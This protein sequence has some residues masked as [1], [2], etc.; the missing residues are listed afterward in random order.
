MV[1]RFARIA[2]FAALLPLGAVPLAASAQPRPAPAPV[3]PGPPALSYADLADLA[4]PAP[5]VTHV[6]LRRALALRPEDSAG[7]AP[8]HT[9]FYME[10]EQV[11]LIR[12]PA[13]A[14]AQIKYLVDLPNQAN[15]R[16]QRPARRSEYLIFAR[17]VPGRAEELQLVAPDAQLPF[18][19]GTADRIRAILREAVAPDAAEAITGIGRA[20]HVPGVLQG[21]SE[22]QVF[23]L[24]ARNQPI[25]ITIR[26]EPQVAPRWF[27]S[28]SEFVDAGATQPA[29]DTLLWYRLACFLP[30]E[31]PRASLSETPEHAR[32]IAA[33][34]ALVRQELG[35]CTRIRPRR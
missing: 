16:A 1:G 18:A 6:R 28:L 2:A 21:A 3:L 9:R 24:T 31:L 4:L 13:G 14:P 7:V 35:A 29:R 15:G 11:A 27:V 30:A 25:S 20:F 22:T 12:G 32:A 5:V 10:A 19:A 17:P 23:L 26:R 8:G 34:Y 33:D